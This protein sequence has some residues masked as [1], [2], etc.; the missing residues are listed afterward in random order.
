MRKLLLSFLMGCLAIASSF[1]TP[2]TDT[3]N[4]TAA[5]PSIRFENIE[6][7]GVCNAPGDY[8]YT[9]DLKLCE[10]WTAVNQIHVYIAPDPGSSWIYAGIANQV[11]ADNFHY[12]LVQNSSVALNPG[13]W[14]MLA[15]YNYTN[16]SGIFPGAGYDFCAGR[17]NFV[18]PPALG[19]CDPCVPDDIVVT[20]DGQ[21]VTN[22]LSY[23]IPC[24]QTCI[25]VAATNVQ[26]AVYNTT[27]PVLTDLQGL[28]CLSDPATTSFTAYITGQDS[29]GD[30]VNIAINVQVEQDCGG[31]DGC[32]NFDST[33]GN[34]QT[35]AA[36][37]SIST[38]G[39]T[40]DGTPY[41]Q[42][43]DGASSTGSWIYNETDLYRRY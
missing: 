30:D 43:T 4:N 31:T 41:M 13:N 3:D 33:V 29:C 24:G 36:G 18:M 15:T 39:P 32:E 11:G 42:G 10:I 12:N 16:P 6:V 7:T 35:S 8:T 9:Y 40:S 21:D 38:A 17:R 14:V 1:A 27:D 23:T 34:W 28:F 25:N 19:D 37:N 2:V 22:T 5:V 20:V 26:N